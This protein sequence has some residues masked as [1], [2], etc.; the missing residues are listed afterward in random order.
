MQKGKQIRKRVLSVLLLVILILVAAFAIFRGYMHLSTPKEYIITSDNY[1]DYQNRYECSGYASAY[2]LRSL[3]QEADGLELYNRFTDKN[4]DGTLAPGYLWENLRAMGY[5]CSL[6]IG[7]MADIKYNVSR[8][9]PVVVLIRVN[10]IQSYLHYVPIVGY[11]E[12]YIYIADSLDYMVNAENENYN[13]KV[14]VDEFKQL[15]KTDTFVVNNIY[16]K[17]GVSK[18][19]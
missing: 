10:T 13:R 14:P 16:L 15:W 17:L 1:F 2:A 4:P 8:G 12:D 11:D 18:N 9:Y 6:R 7:S 3:G 5:K 19:H